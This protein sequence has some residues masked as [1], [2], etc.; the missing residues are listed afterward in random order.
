MKRALS[1]ANFAVLPLG[2]A[3]SYPL[4]LHLDAYISADECLH[5]SNCFYVTGVKSS[6]VPVDNCT[7]GIGNGKYSTT[8]CIQIQLSTVIPRAS[9]EPFAT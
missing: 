2:N 6:E 7:T 5:L 1:E 8:I 4:Y 9:P 3:H